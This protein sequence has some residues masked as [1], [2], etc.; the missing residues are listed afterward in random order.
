MLLFYTS[1]A[2]QVKL[3]AAF[4]VSVI[5]FLPFPLNYFVLRLQD[6]FFYMRHRDLTGFVNKLHDLTCAL[7]V[8]VTE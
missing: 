8:I 7:M 3:N 1:L 4:L 5:Y 6:H 2:W